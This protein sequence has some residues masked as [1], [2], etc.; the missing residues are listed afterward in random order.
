MSVK[1]VPSNKLRV[2][3]PAAHV[4]DAILDFYEKLGINISVSGAGNVLQA[5]S[6]D[7]EIV[8]RVLQPQEIPEYVAKNEI[9]CGFSGQD[10]IEEYRARGQGDRGGD[11]DLHYLVTMESELLG[12]PKTRWVLA[13]P[14]ESTI[15]NVD[16]LRGCIPAARISS[17]IYNFVREYYSSKYIILKTVFSWGAV[18]QGEQPTIVLTRNAVSENEESDGREGRFF[19]DA[20]VIPDSDTL[21]SRGLRSVGT[22]LESQ[23]VFFCNN[24][25]YAKNVWGKE[26]IDEFA[27]LCCARMKAVGNELLRC[28]I[29]EEDSSVLDELCR[30]RGLQFNRFLPCGGKVVFEIVSNRL[31]MRNLIP[32]LSKRGCAISVHPIGMIYDDV[33][34]L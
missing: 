7:S 28:V 24:D 22:V 1:L 18:G 15:Q 14:Q 13:V 32:V 9:D 19:P 6:P 26:K 25:Y 2:G 16:D 3:I 27:M 10:W 17:P 23:T 30:E 12:F 29:K 20:F 21:V 4:G 34:T 5:S 8:P 11:S 31:D 33:T